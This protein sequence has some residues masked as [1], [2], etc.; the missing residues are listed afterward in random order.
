MG[1]VSWWLAWFW[2]YGHSASVTISDFLLRAIQLVSWSVPNNH[3]DSTQ[4]WMLRK[5]SELGDWQETGQ[6]WVESSWIGR[7]ERGLEAGSDEK[8]WSSACWEGRPAAWVR[9]LLQRSLVVGGRSLWRIQLIDLNVLRL[10]L[11]LASPSPP[12]RRARL[13]LIWCSR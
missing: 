10:P 6:S 1:L 7:Y 12:P 13:V 9:C 5:Y 11:H 8:H 3:S 4:L 2:F